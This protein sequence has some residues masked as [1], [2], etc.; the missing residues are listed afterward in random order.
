MFIRSTFVV[1][2]PWEYRIY[3]TKIEMVSY[4]YYS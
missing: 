3:I 4:Q 1:I 2:L